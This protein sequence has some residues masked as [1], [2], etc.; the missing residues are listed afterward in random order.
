M[1]DRHGRSFAADADRGERALFPPIAKWLHTT[2]V[3]RKPAMP[4]VQ[5]VQ[6]MAFVTRVLEGLEGHLTFL[7][8]FGPAAEVGEIRGQVEDAWSRAASRWVL[9]STFASNIGHMIYAATLIQLARDGR[10]DGGEI[11]IL[12]GHTRNPFL[13]GMFDP[14][15][16]DDMPADVPYAEWISTRKRHATTDGG[17]IVM[18]DAVSEAATVWGAGGRPF[19]ALDPEITARGDAALAAMGVP[20]DRPIVT[21]HVREAGYNNRA[22]LGQMRFRDADIA[23]YG[24]AVAWL[25]DAGFHVVRL[26]DPSMAPAPDWPHF[27]DYPFSDGKADWLDICLAARCAFHIGTSSG[28]SFIPL[29]FGRPVVFTNWPTAAHMICAPS[30]I[31]LPKVLVDDTGATVPFADFCGDHR[32]ILEASEAELFGLSFRDNTP[33][34]VLEAVQLMAG[35]LPADGST[36]VLPDAPFEPVWRISTAAPLGTRPR[37]PPG[38][39][40]RTYGDQ[41][42]S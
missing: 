25:G 18:I 30:V 26:G 32:E 4:P 12:R 20:A 22:S 3:E 7:R 6:G 28:M 16:I 10:I 37:I 41:G 39:F 14:Y 33:E 29:L 15:L 36:P 11:S 38:F 40:E 21:L 5:D 1:A 17:R 42:V 19:F 34:E 13:H 8:A 2:F 24:A 9:S 23:S 27:T 35:H 31:N